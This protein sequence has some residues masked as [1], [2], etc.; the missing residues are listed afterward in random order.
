MCGIDT[1][2]FALA[3]RGR[4]LGSAQAVAPEGGVVRNLTPDGQAVTYQRFTFQCLLCDQA[5]IAIL[6]PLC[7]C[8][9]ETQ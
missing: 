3:Q 6:R 1:D 8:S 4:R 9:P 2:D 5:R 7:I